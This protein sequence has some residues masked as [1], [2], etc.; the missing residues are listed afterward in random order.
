WKG[1]EGQRPRLR[2]VYGVPDQPYLEGYSITEF[3]LLEDRIETLDDDTR[4][5]LLDFY[6]QGAEHAA[7]DDDGRIILSQRLREE[8]GL[9]RDGG[10]VIFAGRSHTFR[11]WLPAD[12]EADKAAKRAAIDRIKPAEGSIARLLPRRPRG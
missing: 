8:L 7:V 5:M 12:F 2:L 11:I 10:P 3:A 4:E 9:G 1:A 6:I